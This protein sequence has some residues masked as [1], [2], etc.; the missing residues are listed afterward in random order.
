M[1]LLDIIALFFNVSISEM[2]RLS[3]NKI[4]NCTASSSRQRKL[5]AGLNPGFCLFCFIF[6]F[7]L[8]LFSSEYLNTQSENL[9]KKKS[10]SDT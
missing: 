3:F 4:N 7:V 1:Q 5:L 2:P 8:V 6:S 10:F 9:K